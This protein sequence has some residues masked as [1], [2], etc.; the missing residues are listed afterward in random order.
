[1]SSNKQDGMWEEESSVH[2]VALHKLMNDKCVPV[3]P[4]DKLVGMERPG[5]RNLPTV[6]LDSR[7]IIPLM[8]TYNNQKHQPN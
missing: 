2:R 6:D 7:P 5:R 4:C 8:I 3:K 1:M